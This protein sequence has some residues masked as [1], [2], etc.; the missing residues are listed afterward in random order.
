MDLGT[1]FLNNSPAQLSRLMQ[2]LRFSQ[3][4]PALSA[5]GYRE[6]AALQSGLWLSAQTLL[7]SAVTFVRLATSG[8]GASKRPGALW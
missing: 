6:K 5:T 1:G 3:A 7:F 4:Q 8:G 2:T